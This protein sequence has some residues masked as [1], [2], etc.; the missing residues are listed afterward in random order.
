MEA[1]TLFEAKHIFEEDASNGIHLHCILLRRIP[2]G[3]GQGGRAVQSSL[4]PQ[5]SELVTTRR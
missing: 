5:Q 2:L 3:G 4:E 1:A